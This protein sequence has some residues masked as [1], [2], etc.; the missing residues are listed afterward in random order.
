MTV[1]AEVSLLPDRVPLALLYG[2]TPQA[3]A[4][5]LEHAVLGVDVAADSHLVP[6]TTTLEV[7]AVGE[8][9]LGIEVDRGVAK[10]PLAPDLEGG[11]GVVEL[12]DEPDERLHGYH[13]LAVH[14]GQQRG[15]GVK[16]PQV[17][18]R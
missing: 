9:I 5:D 2:H 8:E 18:R 17:D 14:P 1:V 16:G 7:G 10:Q 11:P 6:E 12:G 3:L 4:F 15:A 13:V